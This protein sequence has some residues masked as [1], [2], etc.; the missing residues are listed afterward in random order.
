MILRTGTLTP[1]LCATPRRCS[2]R[3]RSAD[4]GLVRQQGDVA[5]AVQRRGQAA[6]VAGAGAGHAARQDLAAVAE[7]AAQARHLLVVDDLRVLKAEAADLASAAVE[8]R[9]SARIL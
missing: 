2:L 9:H 7:V 4:F 8:I 3:S 5:G 1:P 6:L